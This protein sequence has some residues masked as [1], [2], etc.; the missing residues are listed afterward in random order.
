MQLWLPLSIVVAANFGSAAR[1]TVFVLQ[2]LNIV[3]GCIEILF[4]TAARTR[5]S[6]LR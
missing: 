4:L 1:Q 2:F 6:I 3:V 5:L